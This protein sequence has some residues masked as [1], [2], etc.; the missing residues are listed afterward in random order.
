MVNWG[1]LS[2]DSSNLFFS[3]ESLQLLDS[4]YQILETTDHYQGYTDK[5]F[6]FA[7]AI[8][9]EN[10]S[11]NGNEYYFIT[12]TEVIYESPGIWQAHS[13]V[14]IYG[15]DIRNNFFE[16]E[17]IRNISFDPYDNN[18]RFLQI[19]DAFY[20]YDPF[21]NEP[22]IFQFCVDSSDNFSYYNYLDGSYTD[23]SY[24]NENLSN[25]LGSVNLDRWIGEGL[26][27]DNFGY[28]SEVGFRDNDGITHKAII[29]NFLSLS[30]ATVLESYTNNDNE[31]IYLDYNLEHAIEDQQGN[32]YFIKR[33]NIYDDDYRT[34]NEIYSL[35]VLNSN[36]NSINDFELASNLYSNYSDPSEN[37]G[38]T[39]FDYFLWSDDNGDS[40]LVEE[41]KT[42]KGV[43][44]S[45]GYGSTYSHTQHDYKAWLID[46]FK[47]IEQ[48]ADVET[49]FTENNFIEDKYPGSMFVNANHQTGQLILAVTSIEP[50]DISYFQS[51]FERIEAAINEANDFD[52]YRYLAS[53]T[54]LMDVFGANLDAASNHYNSFAELENNT[55]MKFDEWSYLASNQDLIS[56]LNGDGYEG[57]KHY[58]N[59]GYREGRS[60]NTFDASN[61]LASNS[62]L[63]SYIGTNS[64]D[65]AKHYSTNGFNEGRIIDSFDEWSYLASNSDLISVIDL[66]L[67][68]D[69]YVQNGF[70]EARGVDTF[71]EWSYL[72]SAGDLINVFGSDTTAATQHYVSNGYKEGRS[73]DSFDEWQYLASNGDL[74]NAFGSDTAT[75]TKHYVYNG[76]TEQ[77]SKDSFDE[78]QYLASNVD[79][80]N[81]FG[82][83]TTAAIQHYVVNGYS[84]GRIK[85]SFD[86]WQYLASHVDLIYAFG[87]NTTAA[88]QHYVANGYTEDRSKDS[89]DELGYLASNNDLINAFGTNT[90]EAVKHYISYGMKEGRDTDGFNA[91]SYLNN[92][93]DLKSAFGN[94]HALAKKHFI[95]NGFAEGRVF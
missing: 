60:I 63:M 43:N 92:Y 48:K 56:A 30:G 66:T 90:T 91:E 77:R 88:I 20:S 28:L 14:N 86:E 18:E 25:L 65:A 49:D 78:W 7:D 17:L 93:V 13:D 85:D 75:A 55:L 32:V 37:I 2:S 33:Q 41:A 35:S 83:D 89:F 29:S 81:A 44:P 39:N 73:K 34:S 94:N 21:S 8:L 59:Y 9:F 69:H 70:W 10:D 22:G 79:L 67:A 47:S 6:N 4:N 72:A 23:A 36:N 38:V 5:Y 24:I 50:Q 46:T 26:Q 42:H 52:P 80:I 11:L 31:H 53:N 58:V 54:H 62:D 68:D 51:A 64:T 61:Y 16:L 74:I 1:K 40:W 71:D 95:E 19:Y 3:D 82:S 84:E 87:S 15:G 57:V 12:E 27:T 76:H 45:E